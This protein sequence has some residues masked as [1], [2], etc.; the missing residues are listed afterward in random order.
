MEPEPQRDRPATHVAYFDESAACRDEVRR[1]LPERTSAILDWA[2]D[3]HALLQRLDELAQE[4]ANVPVCILTGDHGLSLVRLVT[5]VRL[6][7]PDI[8][9]IVHATERMEVRDLEIFEGA[10]L[11]EQGWINVLVGRESQHPTGTIAALTRVCAELI[12]AADD[13]SRRPTT[14]P[15]WLREKRTDARY[16]D[17]YPD[18]IARARSGVI[19]ELTDDQAAGIDPT[20]WG[21]ECPVP[22]PP[23]LRP[24]SPRIILP[25]HDELASLVT[26]G[27]RLALVTCKGM[28]QQWASWMEAKGTQFIGSQKTK[29]D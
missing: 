25:P 28:T 23:P 10:L 21:V 24:A 26:G 3:A 6:R 29:A 19:A 1:L 18:P 9:I 4:R 27:P 2:P 7:F 20:L 17:G 14:K 22:D 11:H 8:R 13:A 16:P 5:A 15:Y 12:Q